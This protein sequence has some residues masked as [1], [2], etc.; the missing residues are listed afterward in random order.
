MSRCVYCGSS[1]NIENDHLIPYS[2]NHLRTIGSRTNTSKKGTVPACHEC[3]NL[4]GNKMYTTVSSRASYLLPKYKKKYDK[5]SRL[6]EWT[7]EELSELGRTLRSAIE[8]GIREKEDLSLRC[9]HVEL[10]SNE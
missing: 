10:V 3:N 4:L 8:N 5:L 1:K 7:E 6:P 9:R 2:Y